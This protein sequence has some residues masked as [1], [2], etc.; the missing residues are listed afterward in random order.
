MKL[1]LKTLIIYLY[2]IIKTTFIKSEVNTFL[3][4]GKRNGTIP[5]YRVE[6]GKACCSLKHLLNALCAKHIGSTEMDEPL[7]LPFKPYVFVSQEYL[8]LAVTTTTNF[9]TFL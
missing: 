1:H 2:I 6:W 5:I 9:K 4:F 3:C 7:F 8:I